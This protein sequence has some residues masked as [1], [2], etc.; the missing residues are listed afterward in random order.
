MHEWLDGLGPV[1]YRPRTNTFCRGKCTVQLVVLGYL[2]PV[3]IAGKLAAVSDCRRSDAWV[4]GSWD[5]G[6]MRKILKSFTVYP[7][8]DL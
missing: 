3:A 7:T 5:R 4:Y 8:Q 1:M 6:F 2:N